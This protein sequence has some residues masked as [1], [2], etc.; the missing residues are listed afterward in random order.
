MNKKQ[1][2]LPGLKKQTEFLFNKLNLE[3][4]NI[5][6]IGSGTS[7]ISKM[8]QNKSGQNIEIIV[9]EYESLLSLKLELTNSKNTSIKLMD[10]ESTDFKDE[11]FDLVYAQGSLSDSRRKK[12]IKEI[13]RI[14][15]SEG[16]FCIGEIVKLE[17][18]IPNFVKDIVESS[19]LSPLNKN[20]IEKYYF[21]RNFELIDSIDL[22]NTLA[23]YYK[24]SSEQLSKSEKNLSENEKSYYKKLLNKIS[25]E[26]NAYLKLGANRYIGF[27][28]L[29]LKNIK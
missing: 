25:H 5:L 3:G 14:L 12:I 17:E 10:F 8:L 18:E 16:Y 7:E 4:F 1:I 20:E 27:L 29:L 28:A 23:D 13:K 19:N 24:I 11:T 22:S 21:D 2:Y 6:I 9:E 26:S 15:K